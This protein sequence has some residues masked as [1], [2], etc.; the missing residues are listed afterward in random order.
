MTG[1][2]HQIRIHFA[3]AGFP[4]E[5]DPYYNPWVIEEM[6]R[7]KSDH[8]KSNAHHNDTDQLDVD[9]PVNMYLQ[10]CS[11]SLPHPSTKQHLKA[12]IPMPATWTKMILDERKKY[13]KTY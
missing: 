5:G 7:L 13:N 2:T 9:V 6:M 4:V 1:K 11:L 12:K 10:A 8:R 3:D